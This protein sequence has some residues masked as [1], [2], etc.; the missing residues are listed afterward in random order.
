MGRRFDEE[1]YVREVLEP[2]READNTPPEDL[3]VRYALTEPLRPDEVAET[4]R[5]VRQCWRRRRGMLRFKRLINRL[6]A[7]H[8]RLAPVFAAAAEGDLG[9]L[10]DALREAGRQ[11]D[12]RLAEARRRLDD[13]AGRLRMLPPDVLA[14]V[15][16]SSGVGRAAAERLAAEL[17][18]EVREPDELPAASPYPG[19][20]QVREALDTLGCRHLAH[21]AYGDGCTGVRVLGGFRPPTAEPLARALD[22]VAAEWARRPRG[23]STTSAETVLAALRAAPDPAALIRYDIVARLRERVREHPYDDTL[24]RH[25][26]EDLG[27]DPGDARRLVFAVRLERG[28]AGGGA[29]AR[30]RELLDAGE[31]QAAVAFADALD[32]ETLAGDAAA[33]AA[34]ARARVAA[35]ER[36]RDRALAA[37]DPDEAWLALQ[38]ALR[39]VPDLPGAREMSSRL[40]PRPV[41]DVRA[42]VV[43]PAGPPAETIREAIL[44]SWQPGSRAGEILYEVTRNGAPF[45]VTGE[46]RV[47]DERPPVNEPLVYR[48]TARRGEALAPPVAAEPVVFRPEPRE[49]R[50]IAGD[51]V[52]TG[53]WSLPEGATRAV[54]TRD[55]VPVECGITGFR[56]RGVVNGTA[57]VY[58]VSAAYPGPG[59]EVITPGVRRRVVPLGRPRPVTDFALEP[60]PAMPGRFLVRCAEPVGGDLE[61]VAL[62]GPPPWPPGT[63]LSVAEVRRAGRPVPVVLTDAGPAVGP[64]AGETLLLAVTVAGDLATVGVCREH[65]NLAVP[66]GLTATRRG[67]VVYVGFDW[68]PDV[69]EVEVRWNGRGMFVSRAAY[70]AQ[71][72][73]R[74]DVPEHEAVAIEVRATAKAGDRRIRGSPAG[75]RLAAQPTVH[76]S[77]TRRG[78]LWRRDLVIE[79]TSDRRLHLPRLRLLLRPG[80]HRPGSPADGRVLAEWTDLEVPARLT[81]PAPRQPRPYWLRCFAE[82]DA[83]LVDPPVRQLKAE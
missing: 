45:A 77:L 54:V 42:E 4:V 25:A 44:V 46:T 72:G 50:L 26:V 37:A 40:P 64:G 21:F 7:D 75:I 63:T 34:E 82:G 31:V 35:A 47:R 17:S 32:E 10:R 13:A 68:P 69:S 78:V 1:R 65:V 6:E 55:G 60:D 19:Y 76:Y 2:A 48:V 53:R 5:L 23:P 62:H 51:G 79:L 16:T 36:L 80:T 28:V 14:G 71:S 22:R 66:T 20:G 67:P 43:V 15:A 41:R 70:R 56:D 38:D 57:H 18:I 3:R 39:Q 9:P 73:V 61:F 83:E 58:V 52:V 8:A 27:L 11:A 12:A 74:L 49:V 30:L 24:L 33:L 29:L 81:V 59:G